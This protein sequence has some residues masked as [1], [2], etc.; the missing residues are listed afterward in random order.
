MQ[1]TNWGRHVAASAKSPPPK[2]KWKTKNWIGEQCLS[3]RFQS[4]IYCLGSKSERSFRCFWLCLLLKKQNKTEKHLIAALCCHKQPSVCSAILPL[5]HCTFL[6]LTPLVCF[7][8]F[9]F[10]SQSSGKLKLAAVPHFVFVP[11]QFAD[12]P[13]WGGD[14]WWRPTTPPPQGGLSVYTAVM[15]VT[16]IR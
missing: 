13:P 1:N 10:F 15:T 12:F 14:A 4:W 3:G 16:T 8:L 6:P 5:C 7:F 11:N 2:K 9:P